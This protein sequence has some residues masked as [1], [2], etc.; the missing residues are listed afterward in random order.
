MT[1][2]RAAIIA[3][4]CEGTSVINDNALEL[5]KFYLGSERGLTFYTILSRYDDYV[6]Y[7]ERRSAYSVGDTLRLIVPFLK[8]HQATTAEVRRLSSRPTFMDGAVEGVQFL[9]NSGAPVF[10]ISTAYQFFATRVA[11]GLRIPLSRLYCTELNLNSC[12]ISPM[13]AQAIREMT[14]EVVALGDFRLP[15]GRGKPLDSHA[16]RVVARLD[17]IFNEVLPAYKCFSL[18]AQTHVLNARQ[19]ANALDMVARECGVPL[20]R[21]VY[22]GDSSTD[23]DVLDMVRDAGGTTIVVNPDTFAFDHAE[24]V[25]AGPTPLGA[26]IL[27][28]V[29]A[30]DGRDG[31]LD[32]SNNWTAARWRAA[33]GDFPLNG[34]A[35]KLSPEGVGRTDGRGADLLRIASLKYRAQLRGT[36]VALLDAAA[37]LQ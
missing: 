13:E 23:W 18:I 34:H 6:G 32:L 35:A 31:A 7:F 22:I 3:T 2:G 9:R 15:S 8:A 26:D 11:R 37:T 28:R 4:D 33:L 16:T 29:A 14:D 1:D 19:K 17:E 21:A 30:Q 24:F 12:L 10:E 20:S 36:D 5:T 25:S 27:A